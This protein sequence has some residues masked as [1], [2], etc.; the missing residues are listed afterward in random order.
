MGAAKSNDDMLYTPHTSHFV[1]VPGEFDKVKHVDD[2]N[3]LI[4]SKTTV[5]SVDSYE[6]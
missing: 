5:S 6:Q 1:P 2:Y 4:Q 3:G